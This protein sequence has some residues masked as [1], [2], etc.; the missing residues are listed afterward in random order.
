MNDIPRKRLRDILG[1]FG[2][3][4]CNDPKRCEALLNDLCPEHKR[5]I[6]ILVA[7]LKEGIVADMMS[8]QG[9]VPLSMSIGRLAKRLHD[10]SGIA[11]QFA[12]WSV[13]SW[14][15]ALGLTSAHDVEKL[16]FTCPRCNASG[17]ASSKHAGKVVQCPKCKGAVRISLDGKTFTPE[18]NGNPAVA[19]SYFKINDPDPARAEQLKE[20][21]V[22]A[23]KSNKFETAI[24]LIEEAVRL[25]ASKSLEDYGIIRAALYKLIGD[26]HPNQAIEMYGQGVNQK[27]KE[28]YMAAISSY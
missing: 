27:S 12:H 3:E 7:A 21:A 8:S 22:N 11:E 4:V 2:H 17:K 5:E 24:R 10:I 26:E 1:H 9:S 13:E 20:E 25:N 23:A 6:R 18:S 14:A 19:E 15:V 28:R 16:Y